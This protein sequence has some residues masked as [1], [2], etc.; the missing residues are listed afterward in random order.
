MNQLMY[1]IKTLIN[2][3]IGAKNDI[4]KHFYNIGTK[5]TLIIDKVLYYGPNENVIE[6]GT[7]AQCFEL[8]QQM[9]GPF[10][11]CHSY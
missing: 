1:H 7:S 4:D 10:L 5:M 9:T 2:I 6:Y 11:R 3:Y 8:L